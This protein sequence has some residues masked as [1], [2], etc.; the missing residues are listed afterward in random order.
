MINVKAKIIV[1]LKGLKMEICNSCGGE[2]VAINSDVAICKICDKRFKIINKNANTN[3][4]TKKKY[5][6]EQIIFALSQN[7]VYMLFGLLLFMLFTLEIVISVGKNV[8]GFEYHFMII[9]LVFSAICVGIFY[10]F[11]YKLGVKKLD[12]REKKYEI[13]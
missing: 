5:T 12:E 3:V 10:Y 2:V 9:D 4:N 6:I 1:I 13:R 7:N 8:F 11:A